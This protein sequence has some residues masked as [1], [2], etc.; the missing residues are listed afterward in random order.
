MKARDWVLVMVEIPIT[1]AIVAF[2]IWF[3]WPYIEWR[4]G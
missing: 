1:V 2:A 4:F 3:W